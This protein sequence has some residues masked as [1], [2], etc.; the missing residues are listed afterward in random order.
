MNLLADALA[1]LTDPQ[2]W[3]GPS[4]LAVRIGEHLGLTFLVVL[5]AALVAVP[6]GVAVG[7]TRRGQGIVSAVAGGGRAIPTLGL[8]TLVGLVAGIGLTAPIVALVV[9]AVPSLLAG[10]SSGIA[11]VEPA[12]VDAARAQGLTTRQV[13]TRLELPLAAPVLVGAFRV[14]TL[15]VVSTATLAAYVADVGLGRVLFAGLKLNDY[16]VVLA[17]ALLVIGL[18]LALELLWAALQRLAAR[19][20]DPASGRT[21][22]ER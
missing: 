7:H 18:A 1:H 11:S 22:D 14:A 10:A 20:A 12:L 3:T 8:L 2:N 21:A 16:P 5:L 17:S 15:Q 19:K 4:G 9:L 13:V 6:V